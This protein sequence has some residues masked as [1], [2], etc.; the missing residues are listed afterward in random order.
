MVL[1]KCKAKAHPRQSAPQKRMQRARCVQLAAANRRQLM[2]RRAIKQLNMLCDERLLGTLR[3]PSKVVVAT[4][5]RVERLVRA[6]EPRCQSALLAARLRAAAREWVANGGCLS[7]PLV[8]DDGGDED[9][10]EELGLPLHKVLQPGFT[11]RTKACM[12][13]YNSKNFTRAT[14]AAFMAWFRPLC[15]KMHVH[16]WSA[17]LEE[18]VHA[19]RATSKGS[20]YHI[21]AYLYWTDGVGVYCRDL[22]RFEFQGTIPNVQRCSA[23]HKV[24]PRTAATHGLW[25]VSVMKTGTIATQTNFVEWVHY[26]PKRVW[27][28]SLYEQGKVSHERYQ[29]L[30]MHFPSGYAA[31][32]RDTEQLVRDEHDLAVHALVARE[33][34]RLETKAWRHFPEVAEF[35]RYFDGS[36]H[37]RRPM[38]A[39]VGDTNC[40]K[41]LLGGS[42][43]QGLASNLG[44]Q[45]YLEITVE[46]DAELDLRDFRV[47]KHSGILL[48]GVADVKTLKAH[49][50]VLQ[51]RPKV[52]KGG[53]SATMIYAYSYTLCNRA[54]IAT[55][56]SAA[57]NLHMLTTDHWLSCN[58]NVI[59]LRLSAPAWVGSTVRAGPAR[60]D[61]MMRR[62]SVAEVSTFLLARDLQGPASVCCAS[63]VN[64]ADLYGL[65]AHQLCHEVRLTPF[66][67]RK[68][69][70]ARDDFLREGR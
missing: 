20:R 45:S 9:G 1:A 63:G 5:T 31:R 12:L 16:R 61:A 50:E 59:V 15:K 68:V 34:Q 44:V 14:W 60:R 3:I 58:K 36:P 6:L 41:S 46:G 18:S 65:T 4:D 62:W 19:E 8:A 49:R 17:C 64:G 22:K 24:T 67:A 42:I 55:L 43:L 57:T 32:K 23:G 47:N 29:E 37:H 70:A 53:R 33:Q 28:D 38:L 48:D 25:Y 52:M 66:A 39:I 7:R 10:P 51:G 21:H 54:V 13:T 2:R 11:L 40:G 26:V 69:V 30:S 35:E 56:D 27:L